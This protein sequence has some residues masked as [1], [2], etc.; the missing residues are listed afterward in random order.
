MKTLVIR[1]PPVASGVVIG[2]TWAPNNL[3]RA[4]GLDPIGPHFIK[5]VTGFPI[6]IWGTSSMLILRLDR[7]VS[8][9]M[10]TL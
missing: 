3:N 6:L 4:F 2:N 8:L 10:S 1:K 9:S 5:N 7:Q